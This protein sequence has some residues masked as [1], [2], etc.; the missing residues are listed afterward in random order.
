MKFLGHTSDFFYLHNTAL[1]FQTWVKFQGEQRNIHVLPI[2]N[3][4]S[5]HVSLIPHWDFCHFLEWDTCVEALH[6]TFKSD[7]K[8]KEKQNWKNQLN[9]V[10]YKYWSSNQMLGVQS[11][12][13]CWALVD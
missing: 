4:F 5:A 1:E 13:L 12:F 7:W 6:R 3:S 11:M 8:E 2:W 9:F 10:I